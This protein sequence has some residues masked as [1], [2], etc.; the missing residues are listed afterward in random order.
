MSMFSVR[1]SRVRGAFVVAAA[2]TVL[3]VTPSLAVAD[4]NDAPGQTQDTLGLMLDDNGEASEV[5]TMHPDG[6]YAYVGPSTANGFRDS[7][8]VGS[9]IFTGAY[10]TIISGPHVTKVKVYKRSFHACK[11]QVAGLVQNCQDGSITYAAGFAACFDTCT[12][13]GQRGSHRCQVDGSDSNGVSSTMTDC[14]SDLLSNGYSSK[15]VETDRDCVSL[16]CSSYTW[17]VNAYPTGNI[18]GPYS[19]SGSV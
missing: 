5:V 15:A 1:G 3:G 2:V 11:G 7:L 16:G 19:G 9:P 18:T 10:K 6:S 4:G 8:S 13:A 12:V 17:H 14:Y